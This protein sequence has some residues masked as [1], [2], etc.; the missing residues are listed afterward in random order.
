VR[1]IELTTTEMEAAREE[2]QG[3]ALI[4]VGSIE[5]HGPHLPVGCDAFVADRVADLAAEEEP[6]VVLPAMPYTWSP[7]ARRHPGAITVQSTHLVALLEDVCD[8]IWRNGFPK[9]ALLHAHG[10]NVPMDYLMPAHMVERGKP[11]ALYSIGPWGGLDPAVLTRERARA[12]IGHAC[13]VESSSLMFVRPDLVK[14]ANLKGEDISPRPGPAVGSAQTGIG[15][16]ESHPYGV[17]GQPALATPQLGEELIRGWA[18]GVAAILRR[19]KQD[20]VTPRVV[21]EFARPGL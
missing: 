19:I 13:H 9:I 15:W 8:E 21:A 1:W 6:V 4:P 10:G 16:I 18:K 14:M 12:P 5:T 20:E 3:V 7:Q 17:I 11:Y 2:A